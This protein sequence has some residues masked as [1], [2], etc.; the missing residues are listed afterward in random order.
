MRIQGCIKTK[1]TNLHCKDDILFL[2]CHLQGE[3]RW[4]CPGAHGQTTVEPLT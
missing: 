3:S 2:P 4:R 1:G